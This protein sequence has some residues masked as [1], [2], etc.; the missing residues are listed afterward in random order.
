MVRKAVTN[1]IRDSITKIQRVHPVL[2]DH[3]DNA[4]HTGAFCSYGPEQPV[5]WKVS[6]A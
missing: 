4:V 6:G 3:L 2:G 5:S 1:R